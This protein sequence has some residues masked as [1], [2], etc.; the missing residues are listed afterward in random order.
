M[1]IAQKIEHEDMKNKKS[2]NPIQSLRLLSITTKKGRGKAS[3][4]FPR[5]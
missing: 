4:L 5:R 2:N 1:E 3:D